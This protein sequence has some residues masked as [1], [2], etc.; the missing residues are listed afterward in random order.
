MNIE[1]SISK[2]RRQIT[3][4]KCEKNIG[5][6]VFISDLE[7]LLTAYEKQ[8]KIIDLMAEDIIKYETELG[9]EGNYKN[10]EEVIKYFKERCK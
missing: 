2:L 3:A 10:E 8:N 6:P 4:G 5:I 7:T 1:E 9:Y